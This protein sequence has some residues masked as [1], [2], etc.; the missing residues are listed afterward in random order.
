M[1]E[2]APNECPDCG[3]YFPLRTENGTCQK[4]QKLAAFKRGTADYEEHESHAQCEMCGLT[5][6]NNMP[7]VL[8][9][10]TCGTTC[11]VDEVRKVH[12]RPGS[13]QNS[14]VPETYKERAARTMSRFKITVTKP[15]TEMHTAAL[16]HHEQ[17]L[18][19]PNE[20]HIKLAIATRFS[21]SKAVSVKI[22]NLIKLYAVSAQMPDILNDALQVVNPQIVDN[23]LGE[24]PVEIKEVSFRFPGNRLP[25]SNSSTGTL[26]N[27]Y[28]VHSS[29]KSK[30]ATYIENVPTQFSKLARGGKEKLVCLEFVINVDLYRDR[31]DREREMSPA[32]TGS[33][34]RK[35][36]ASSASTSDALQKRMRPS[37]PSGISLLGS[38]IG[39]RTG[40]GA[41]IPMQPQT[42]SSVS[43]E[44]FIVSIDPLDLTPELV[45]RPGEVH[46]LV[47]DRHFAKGQMK[48]A[49]DMV[50]LYEDGL[51]ERVVAKRLYRTSSD[52]PD[53]TSNMVGLVEN[54]TMLEAECIRLGIGEKILSEFYSFCRGSKVQVYENIKFAQGFLVTE[55]PIA[56]TRPPSVASGLDSFHPV[57]NGM[58]WLVEGKR[59]S[60]V[61]SFTSTLDHKARGAEDSQ[62]DT[63]H[64]F[65]HF[66]FQ[67]SEGSLVFADLQGTPGPVRGNDGLI[68]FDPMTHTLDGGSGLG[69][70][71]ME[72]IESF[73]N[74]HECNRLC[75]QLHLEALE[76][77]DKPAEPESTE[78]SEGGHNTS[79]DDDDG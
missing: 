74:G 14:T 73:V 75:E 77:V 49:H 48:L 36:T 61:I 7:L 56:V 44:K 9:K 78:P 33:T 23:K 32:V 17:G 54:R 24:R 63:V 50:I 42:Q 66:V 4:C 31:V 65:A 58:T 3:N 19:N 70:F 59:A 43:L 71:G 2:P 26:A 29:T 53:S 11:C 57:H 28:A 35:R 25:E 51:E 68:L 6:R 55:I 12:G 62:S 40:T 21:D 8:E 15:G 79:D 20:E 76:L 22:G 45:K 5:R 27:F 13:T 10:Q 69:D 41:L 72:G 37:V 60:V 30:A 16:L 47:W 52:D 46:A 1:S 64:A 67:Y 34:V 18:G 38:R 39:S